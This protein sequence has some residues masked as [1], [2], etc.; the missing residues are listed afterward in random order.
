MTMMMATGHSFI[1]LHSIVDMHNSILNEYIVL[2]MITDMCVY[3]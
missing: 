3:T 2:L 1:V